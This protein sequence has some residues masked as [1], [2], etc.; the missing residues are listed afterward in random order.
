MKSPLIASLVL[1]LL[2]SCSSRPA[3]QTSAPAAD[4]HAGWT[5]PATAF[6]DAPGAGKKIVL[7][8]YTDWCGWCKRMDRDTY[9]DSAVSSYM[10]AHYLAA[11]MNPEKEGSLTYDGQQ[12]THADFARGLGIRGY[13][14][15][16]FFNEKGELL[17]M[18][19]GYMKPKEFMRVLRYFGDDIY[20]TKK[21]DEYTAA[22]NVREGSAE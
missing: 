16:A 19:S 10:G 1:L 20:L 14:A 18:V 2:C 4:P 17:T 12:V 3:A 15:T 13:P 8:V 5:T 21:W 6:S 7:D 22:E 9:A 11:K